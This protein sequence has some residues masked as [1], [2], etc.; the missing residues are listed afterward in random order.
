MTLLG[1]GAFHRSCAHT[2][3]Q[4]LLLQLLRYATLDSCEGVHDHIPTPPLALSMSLSEAKDLAG[5]SS[6]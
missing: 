5:V 1:M 3:M 2:R 4:Q 6:K